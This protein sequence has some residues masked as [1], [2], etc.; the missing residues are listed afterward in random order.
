MEPSEKAARDILAMLEH[1][2][3]PTHQY[4]RV[5]PSA[6]PHL[7]VRWYEATTRELASKGFRHLADV[8]DKTI[9]ATPGGVLRPVLL[10]SLISRDGTVMSAL[11]HPRLKPLWL[12]LL[13]W[14]LRKTPGK[15]TDMESEFTDASFVV[16]SNA[17]AAA[18][19]DAPA[20]ISS[21]FLPTTASTL[22]V[23]TRHTARVAAH[24]A[25]RPGVSARVV[26]THDEYVA[27]QNRMNALKAAFRGQIGGVTKEELERLSIFGTSVARDVHSAVVQ[28]QQDRAP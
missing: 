14:L 16:T 7:D 27:S 15:V 11:Y 21:E 23:L 12:R 20:L 6:F 25:E 1:T 3:Q 4:V 24:L 8:E 5:Q 19:L 2:Y 10:R 28:Q 17:A 22:E 18:A 13:M 26:T 9:T